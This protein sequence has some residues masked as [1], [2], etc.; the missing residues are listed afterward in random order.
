MSSKECIHYIMTE[1]QLSERLQKSIKRIVKA[2]GYETCKVDIK[3]VSTNGGNYLADLYEIDAKGKT[4]EG[5]KE[6]NLFVKAIKKA[7][8]LEDIISINDVYSTEGYF[9]KELSKFFEDLQNQAMVPLEDRFNMIRSYEETNVEAIILE[10]LA[11]KGFKTLYR[12]DVPSLKFVEQCI[13]EIAKFHAFSYVIK[14]RDPEYFYEKISSRKPLIKF[15]TKW[16][17]TAIHL[18]GLLTKFCDND[19]KKKLEDFIPVYVKK[20]R[21]YFTDPESTI[22]CLLHGDFRISNTLTREMVSNVLFQ[23][24]G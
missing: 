4:V 13:Q 9:Y 1:N 5:E 19:L 8:L 16:E 6:T 12:M 17:K 3:L 21:Q 20:L 24:Y 7:D 15:G 10:N 23:Q 14:K 11:K 2:E 18:A 22:C